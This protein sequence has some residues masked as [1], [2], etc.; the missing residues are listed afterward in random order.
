MRPRRYHVTLTKEEHQ[1]LN[2][3]TR[4]GTASAQ[5]IKHAQIILKLDETFNEKPWALEEIRETYGASI[6]TICSAAQRF[7]GEGMDSALN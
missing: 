3:L 5:K 2:E 1:Y 4:K 6:G 7:V